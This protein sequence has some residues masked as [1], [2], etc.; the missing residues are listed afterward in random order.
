MKLRAEA[1]GRDCLVR[2]PGV[3]NRDASTTVLAHF[4]LAGTCGAGIKP[5]D[6]AGAWCCSACHDEIDGRTH[7]T[8]WARDVLRLHHAEGVFRTIAALAAKGVLD[9]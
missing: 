1:R 2:I 6:L 5:H 3:C 8:G 9:D 7:F 4:R